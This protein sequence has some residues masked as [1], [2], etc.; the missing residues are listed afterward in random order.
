MTRCIPLLVFGALLSASSVSAHGYVASVKVG[1]KNLTGYLPFDDP[2]KQPVP[3]RVV[4]PI[5]NDGPITALTSPDLVCNKGGKDGSKST[6][7]AATAGSKMTFQWTAWPADH[8]GPVTTWMTSCGGS[9]KDF[10]PTKAKFFKIDEAGLSN[11]KWASSKLI[12]QGNSWTV[13][14]PKSLADG[15]YLVRHE[16]MAMHDASAAQMYPSCVGIKVTGGGSAKPA[17][18][19]AM[20]ITEAYKDF[21]EPDIWDDSFKSFKIQGPKVASLTSGGSGDDN[22]DDPEGTVTTATEPSSTSKGEEPTATSES[23]SVS[24]APTGTKTRSSSA[25]PTS[26]GSSHCRRSSRSRRG[27]ERR[28]KRRAH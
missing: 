7:A 17:P 24:A 2:Y 6:V 21:K 11:G 16:I 25:S 26:S 13:T 14:I 22:E 9:C 10:D 12:E 15:E 27:M 20:T 19:D 28:H 8:L 3:S 5:P 18:G 4:R 1:G 23:E